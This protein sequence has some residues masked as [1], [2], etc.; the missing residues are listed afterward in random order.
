MI[1]P[2][3]SRP[4][5]GYDYEVA[6]CETCGIPFWKKIGQR[7]RP[8]VY[9]TKSCSKLL[10]VQDWLYNLILNP[11]FNPSREKAVQLRQVLWQMGNELNKYI[12]H[13]SKKEKQNH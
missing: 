6:H 12:N 2:Q 10:E 13:G 1:K 3:Q 8:Q 11:D 4:D 5:D 9:C 7:G